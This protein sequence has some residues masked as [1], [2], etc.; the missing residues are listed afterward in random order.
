M[1]DTFDENANDISEKRRECVT[2]RGVLR[3]IR[4]LVY[5]YATLEIPYEIHMPTGGWDGHP[6]GYINRVPVGD[7]D[8][9]WFKQDGNVYSDSTKSEFSKYVNLHL[10]LAYEKMSPKDYQQKVA[11]SAPISDGVFVKNYHD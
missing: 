9:D 5:D 3:K 11:I 2:P 8:F 1:F 10:G 7:R 6:S 4:K